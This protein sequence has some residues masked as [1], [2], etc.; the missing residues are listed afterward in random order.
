MYVCALVKKGVGS[1]SCYINV[2]VI[3]VSPEAK[4]MV[5]LSLTCSGRISVS[6]PLN[7]AAK[8]L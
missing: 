1:G 5:I 7:D 4:G 2:T 3:K 6:M 8:A